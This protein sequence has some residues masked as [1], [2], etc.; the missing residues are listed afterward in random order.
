MILINVQKYS[1]CG[2]FQTRNALNDGKYIIKI[3]RL[4]KIIN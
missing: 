1:L 2:Y 4:F 3:F